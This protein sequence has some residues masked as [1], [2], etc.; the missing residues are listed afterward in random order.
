MIR[1]LVWVCAVV[2]LVGWAG[3]STAA[4]PIAGDSPLV[5]VPADAPIVFHVKGVERVSGRVKALSA[6]AAPELGKVL[7]QRVDQIFRQVLGDRKITGVPADGPI[8]L[9]TLTLP[10]GGSEPPMAV[11]ARVTKYSDFRDGLLTADEKKA[12]KSEGGIEAVEIE[13]K[14]VFLVDR[15]NFAIIA[16]EKGA[17]ETL[18]KKYAGLDSKLSKGMAEKFLGY[19]LGVY[20]D[21]AVV[22]EKQ[23]DAIRQSRDMLLSLAEQGAAGDPQQAEAAQKMIGGLFQAM[24]DSRGFVV[25]ADFR[26]EGLALHVQSRVG[27]E[28]ES[29]AF[30]KSQK[31]AALAGIGTLP[32]DQMVYMTALL[33]PDSMKSIMTIGQ[34][35]GTPNEAMKKAIQEM[36][37]AGPRAYCSAASFPLAQLTAQEFDNPKKAIDATLAM[38][39]A[40]GD[41][42]T[43][44][45]MMLKG[46]PQVKVDA[47]THKDIKFTEYKMEFDIDKMAEKNPAGAE[48]TKAMMNKMMGGGM[49]GWIGTDG[50]Q[51]INVTGKD[52]DVAKATLDAYLAGASTLAKSEAFQSTRKALPAS[53]SMLA[54]ADAGRLTFA[55][56]DIGV[57]V[58]KSM[59]GLGLPLP[60]MPDEIKPVK[61]E[62]VYIGVAVTLQPESGAFDLFFPAKAVP[63]IKKVV[64]QLFMGS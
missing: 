35:A 54:V 36:V 43:V 64:M 59:G 52:W 10:Q 14:T 4:D 17:A 3:P 32:S 37:A 9:A 24:L 50:K 25:A 41:E 13:G 7:E 16:T 21:M 22:N 1:R 46:P 60:P 8:F 53:A 30:L 61:T 29:N 47:K 27:A 42:E 28:T 33:S 6:A 39:R 38:F 45:R 51:V 19:D 34:G 56:T 40:M 44:A 57:T 63:E 31:P 11:I 18:A 15:Q 48:A 2:A 23:G 26:P 62:T 55:L 58:M 5:A 20:V 49:T 12:A